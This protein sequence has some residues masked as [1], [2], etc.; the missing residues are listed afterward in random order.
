MPI[1]VAPIGEKLKVVKILC[2]CS[3]KKDLE[4]A[5]VIVGSEI[6]V[7]EKECYNI[8]CVVGGKTIVIDSEIA[9]KILVA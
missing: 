2:E 3:E 5:N 9:T 1:I 6:V 4:L 8:I 7:L